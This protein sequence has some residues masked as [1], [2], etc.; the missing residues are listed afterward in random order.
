MGLEIENLPLVLSVLDICVC[1]H[2]QLCP[3]PQTATSQAH[4]S[5]G[6]PRQE[7]C[8]GLPFPPP[9]NLPNP[10]I[11]PASLVSAVLAGGFFT[12]GATC[13]AQNSFFGKQLSE[14]Q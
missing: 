1:V 11:E 7:Y 13:E 2:A 5:M 9:G 6:F 8:S 10:G 14:W 12:T 4:L 3:T